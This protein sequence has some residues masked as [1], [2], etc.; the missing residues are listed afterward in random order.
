MRAS[1]IESFLGLRTP[2]TQCHAIE[3][4]LRKVRLI[5]PLVSGT[6]AYGP[7]FVN[8]LAKVQALIDLALQSAGAVEIQLP[9]LQPLHLWEN[10]RRYELFQSTLF[11]LQDRK[12]RSLLLSPTSEEQISDWLDQVRPFAKSTFPLILYQKN[13]KFRDEPGAGSITRTR[14][15]FMYDCYIWHPSL[16]QVH[17]IG[18]TIMIR[19]SHV[20][21]LLNIP[22][23]QA[24]SKPS[25]ATEYTGYRSHDLFIPTKIGT[26]NHISVCADC[27]RVLEEQSGEETGKG[28]RCPYCQ[29]GIHVRIRQVMEVARYSP[30]GAHFSRTF[31]VTSNGTPLNMGCVGVGPIRVIMGILGQLFDGPTVIWPE[32]ATPVLIAVITPTFKTLADKQEELERVYHALQT[33][34][35]CSKVPVFLRQSVILDDRDLPYSKKLK[36]WEERGVPYIID[37]GQSEANA[38]LRFWNRLEGLE[39]IASTDGIIALGE[40]I[41]R[42]IEEKVGQACQGYSL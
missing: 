28:A 37:A 1:T 38:Q 6:Y 24:I 26:G 23:Y 2:P 17:Q 36:E 10:S 13:H 35:E 8:L 14:Q 30:L 25:V 33:S 12:G 41:F 42:R 11:T 20:L 9:I 4:Y 39:Q 19:L 5:Y 7:L 32:L 18:N 29:T 27:D 22:H 21:D 15:F 16:E 3:Q 31:N 40:K 34:S